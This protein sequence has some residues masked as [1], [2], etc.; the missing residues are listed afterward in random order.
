MISV[1]R[2][3]KQI[4]LNFFLKKNVMEYNIQ[5]RLSNFQKLSVRTIDY[6]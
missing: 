1:M 3:F 4:E 2:K 5:F 6:R